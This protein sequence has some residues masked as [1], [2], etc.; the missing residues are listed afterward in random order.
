MRAPLSA[1][2]PLRARAS[3]DY[4]AEASVERRPI[5]QPVKPSTTL[6]MLFNQMPYFKK[7]E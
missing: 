4:P 7:T 5:L 2:E 6:F 3:A 1:R